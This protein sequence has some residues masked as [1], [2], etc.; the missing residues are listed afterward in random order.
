VARCYGSG[1]GLWAIHIVVKPMIGVLMLFPVTRGS[2]DY[3]DVI[4]R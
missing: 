2:A 1:N 4:G 3:D